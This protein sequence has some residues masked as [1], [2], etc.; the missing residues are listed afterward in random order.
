MELVLLDDPPI[1][2][3]IVKVYGLLKFTGHGVAAE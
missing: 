1:F 3:Q 2:E